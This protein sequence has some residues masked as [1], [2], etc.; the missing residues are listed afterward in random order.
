MISQRDELTTDTSKLFILGS[1][2]V[3]RK[4]LLKSIGLFPDRIEKPGVD[5]TCKANEKPLSYVKRIAEDKAKAIKTEKQSFL[6]TADT[7]VVA[8][9]RI[10]LKTYDE[11]IARNYLRLLS[12]RRHTVFTAF[13]IKHNNI[14]SLNLVKT[15][16]KMRLL[17][18]EE[19]EAYISS[20]EWL[21]CAGA[22]SIQ[23]RAKVFFPIISG[24]F[25]NVIGLPLPKLI[26]VLKGMGFSQ[27][28]HEQRNNY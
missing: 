25:S 13:C 23:G 18:E 28:N 14:I 7:I 6:I 22:Y 12:G 9:R 26:S 5:E 20:K 4:D 11:T 1:G 8:G 27:N 21:G 10:L 15:S 17:I 2:S 3:A 19:I 24:C 16:L